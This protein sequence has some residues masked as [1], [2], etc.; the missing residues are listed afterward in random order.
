VLKFLS[1]L[2]RSNGWGPKVCDWS[3]EQAAH[4]YAE[5]CRKAE[6]ERVAT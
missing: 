1:D 3:P 5:A 4:A 6:A 2:G